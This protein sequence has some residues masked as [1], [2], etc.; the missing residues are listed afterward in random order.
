MELCHLKEIGLPMASMATLNGVHKEPRKPKEAPK[1][2]HTL[3]ATPVEKGD[4]REMRPQNALAQPATHATRPLYMDGTYIFE[5]EAQV[6]EMSLN[7][8]VLSIELDQTL[9]H[10][11]GGGQPSDT[12]LLCAKGLSDLSVVFVSKDKVKEGVI[13]HDCKADEAVIQ[14]WLSHKGKELKVHCKVDEPKRRLAARLHSAGH[15]LDVAIFGLGFRW[16]AGKGYHFEE[17]PYVEYIPTNEGRQL[18]MKDAKAKTV[19]MEEISAKM[20]ELVAK[21]ISTEI[22]FVDGMRTISMD[23]VSCGCGG[24]HVESSSE[25]GE[26]SIKKIQAKQG[27]IRVSYAV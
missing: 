3:Q 4:K 21:N 1:E 2:A 11:Q 16:Q 20:K 23:G 27:N 18:D 26:V 24:T 7:E 13:R 17:G 14:A 8:G 10:P 5:C 15:L 22:G 6:R 9:F 12:G 19:A 25:I